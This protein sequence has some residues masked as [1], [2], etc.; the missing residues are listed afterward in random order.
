MAERDER[1]YADIKELTEV[2]DA[3]N[4]TVLLK[5]GWELLAIKEKITKSPSSET[6]VVVYV[7][8][9]KGSPTPT[10]TPTKVQV[11]APAPSP[12]PSPSPS[13]QVESK[14]KETQAQPAKFFSCRYCGRL[15]RWNRSSEGKWLP[16]NPDGSNHVCKREG[17]EI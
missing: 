3:D 4:A 7:M 10:S 11:P 12:S 1:Y 6:K 9:K 5:A 14:A 2:S 16:T 17:K 15:V 13:A 8:G